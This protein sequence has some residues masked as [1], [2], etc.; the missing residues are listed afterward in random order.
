MEHRSFGVLSDRGSPVSVGAGM[1]AMVRVDL[2][3]RIHAGA[4]QR[5]GEAGGQTRDYTT[6]GFMWRVDP[7]LNERQ[8]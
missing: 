2:G 7:C 1:R 6:L 5:A 4:A 8:C 3:A